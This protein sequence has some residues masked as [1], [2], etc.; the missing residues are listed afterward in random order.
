MTFIQ[1]VRR[2]LCIGRATIAVEPIHARRASATTVLPEPEIEIGQ[3][4]PA[5]LSP[6]APGPVDLATLDLDSPAVRELR[7]A[8][9]VLV[10]PLVSHGKLAR[11]R[12]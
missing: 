11:S 12:P 6:A 7:E 5:G 1:A 2:T 4:I 10:V 3:R 8:G 9:V